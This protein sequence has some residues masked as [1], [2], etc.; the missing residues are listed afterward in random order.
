[1]YGEE[2]GYYSGISPMMKKHL[3]K[4]VKNHLSYIKN[5]SYILDIGSNDGT[6][7]NAFLKYNKSLNLVGIADFSYYFVIY[8]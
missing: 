6:L 8:V 2:Y 4:I 5:N 3:N 1:M 7:L